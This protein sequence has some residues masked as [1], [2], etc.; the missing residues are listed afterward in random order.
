MVDKRIASAVPG[1]A[2]RTDA[3]LVFPCLQE[4]RSVL[5]QQLEY[6]DVKQRNIGVVLRRFPDSLAPPFSA[7]DELCAAF[8]VVDNAARYIADT[9]KHLVDSENDAVYVIF[10]VAACTLRDKCGINIFANRRDLA[11]L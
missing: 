3:H 1:V 11:V 5:A 10:A 9:E 8:L 7:L 4:R 2:F 6:S